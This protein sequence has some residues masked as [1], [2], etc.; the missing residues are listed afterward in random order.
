MLNEKMLSQMLRHL[1]MEYGDS[2]NADRDA[3]LAQAY[4]QL[5]TAIA[6]LSMPRPFIQIGEHI[7]NRADIIRVQISEAN[8]LYSY[9]HIKIYTRDVEGSEEYGS[10][11]NWIL[12]AYGSPEAQ[13]FLAWIAE[14]SEILDP[15]SE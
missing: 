9:K 5:C 6:A 15:R 7:I 13:I 3:Q 11:S 14:Q 8:S 12:Y 2:S 10:S 1:E 4:A